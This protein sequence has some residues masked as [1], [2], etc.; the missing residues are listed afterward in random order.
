MSVLLMLPHGSNTNRM[1]KGVM[2]GQGRGMGM[3]MGVGTG[4][5]RV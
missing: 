1:G 3:G 2:P 4:L 5:G